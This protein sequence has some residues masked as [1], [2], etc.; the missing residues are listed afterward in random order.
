MERERQNSLSAPVSDLAKAADSFLVKRG[1][2]L[3][4]IAGYH[5]F[6][7]WG[8]DAMIALPGLLLSTNR[9]E[10][11]RSVLRSFAE[12]MKGGVLPNDLG[13][14]SYNTVDASLWFIQAVGKYYDS[15]KDQQF[16]AEL[17]PK[18]LDVVERYSQSGQDFG[19]DEDGLIVSGP[20]LTWMDA[21][22]ETRP[23]TPRMGKCCEINSLWYS[24]LR[25]ME[26]LAKSLD[27]PLDQKISRPGR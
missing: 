2:N 13:A 4:L 26:S 18:L 1:N 25:W 7:D 27:L 23:I 16:V 9:F 12:A 11:A 24:A 10:E 15:S 22:V 6:N 20:A 5:W 17:W 8:R 14:L 19:A 3:S 21:R